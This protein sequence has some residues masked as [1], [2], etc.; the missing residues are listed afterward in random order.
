MNARFVSIILALTTTALADV[1]LPAIFSEHVVL[2]R[3]RPLP[4]WGWADAGEPVGVSLGAQKANAK[5]DADGRWMV[6]LAAQ[7]ASPFRTDSW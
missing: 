3:D 7:P 1:R 5:A 2:Q 6:K 4:V